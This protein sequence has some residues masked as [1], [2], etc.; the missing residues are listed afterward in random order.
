LKA[1]K[2]Q[3]LGDIYALNAFLYIYGMS[4]NPDKKSL[5]ERIGDFFNSIIKPKAKEL[6]EKTREKIKQTS[7]YIAP[8]AEELKEKAKVKIKQTSEYIAP[9][10]E[11]FK[12]KTKKATYKLKKIL[13]CA[14]LFSFLFLCIFFVIFSNNKNLH[15]ISIGVPSYKNHWELDIPNNQ[16]DAEKIAE[17]LQQSKGLFSNV[18]TITIAGHGEA[19]KSG[20][21][22]TIN[23]VYRNAGDNDVVLIYISSHGKKYKNGEY[24]LLPYDFDKRKHYETSLKA[25]NLI[26]NS[27]IK[28]II[29]IDAC[30]S[31]AAKRDLNDNYV[32]L[33]VSSDENECSISTWDGSAF[34]N[35]LLNGLDCEAD[36]NKN[37][38]I[39]LQ[40]ITS[41]VVKNV[42][43]Q[44]ASNPL[45]NISDVNL[46]KCSD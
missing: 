24:L 12:E 32:N 14:F 6:K 42:H 8:K 46:V 36:Y 20:V 41:Y 13:I 7:E 44:K 22:K 2:G 16:Y 15:I 31:G 40:E 27:R 11:E 37:G 43:G 23:K 10:A 45:K 9:K 21:E 1:I 26:K 25:R 38:I 29:W 33:L 4:Q 17:I 28:T 18:N 5:K 30:E 39:S 35:T 19:T 34:T 3:P